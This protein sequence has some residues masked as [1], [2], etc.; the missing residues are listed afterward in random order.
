M[1]LDWIE[2]IETLEEITNSKTIFP[3]EILVEIDNFLL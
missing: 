1:P 2:N 3:Y